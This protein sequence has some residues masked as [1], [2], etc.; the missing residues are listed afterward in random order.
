MAINC[1]S[2]IVNRLLQQLIQVYSASPFSL[3]FQIK[4]Y[5]IHLHVYACFQILRIFETNILYFQVR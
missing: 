5:F 1:L 4:Y 3:G 2:N